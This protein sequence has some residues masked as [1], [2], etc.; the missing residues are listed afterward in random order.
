MK[1]DQMAA[2]IRTNGH[3]F[4]DLALTMLTLLAVGFMKRGL[5]DQVTQIRPK[6]NH[7]DNGHRNDNDPD[8][9]DLGHE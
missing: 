3:G 4:G 1:D 6:N 9:V 2:A 7:I 8:V 5:L